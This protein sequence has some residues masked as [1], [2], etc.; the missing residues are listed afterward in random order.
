MI[1]YV[2]YPNNFSSDI[3][4]VGIGF[5]V[6]TIAFRLVPIDASANEILFRQSQP[7][8]EKNANRSSISR[9]TKIN[10]KVYKSV[11]ALDKITLGEEDGKTK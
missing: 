10:M 5:F 4:I 2:W 11:G 8:L 3:F 1:Y 6:E 7:Q 9:A